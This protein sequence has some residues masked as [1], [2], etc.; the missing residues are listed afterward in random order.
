MKKITNEK[1][2]LPKFI[3]AVHA[4]WV[5]D[6]LSSHLIQ[7]FKFYEDFTVLP[8]LTE[9][10]YREVQNLTNIDAILPVP[11][12]AFRL[13]KRGFNQAG[14]IGKRL[15]KQMQLPFDDAMLCKVKKTKAQAGLQK[16]ARHENIKGVF[17]I[18]YGKNYKNVVLL[19]DVMTTG[20]TVSELARILK[21]SGVQ[22]VEVWVLARA[23]IGV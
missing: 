1:A 21:K 9:S 23:L 2:K 4:V 5:Y 15:A 16:S 19:D 17:E 7:R 11:L 13:F 22:R 10:L 18:K 14:E 20:S 12:H 3:D 8:F 6:D